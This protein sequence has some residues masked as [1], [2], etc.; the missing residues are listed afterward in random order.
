VIT[1][2]QAV[3]EA[4]GV[5]KLVSTLRGYAAASGKAMDDILAQEARQ[6]SWELYR[7]FRKLSP[8]PADILGAA[9]GRSWRMGRVGNALTSSHFGI[10]AAADRRANALLEGQPSDYFRVTTDG[11]GMLKVRR[12][13]FSGRR[14]FKTRTRLSPVL[15]GGRYGNKFAAGSLRA[16]QV[17]RFE[18]GQAM[19]TNRDIKRLNLGALSAAVEIAF[20]QRAAKGSTLAVQWLPKVYRTRKSSMVKNG[21]LIV[22]SPATGYELGRVSFFSSDGRLNRIRID[23][24][25]P[26]TSKVM[27]R[28]GVFAQVLAERVRDRE[29]YIR[30]KMTG[31]KQAAF[32]GLK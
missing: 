22:N 4:K 12:V 19:R 3:I 23:A 11:G 10:S 8:K 29:K 20:R 18:I 17:S 16:S 24:N 26:G 13:R 31:A 2:G 28:S 6:M 25:A 15:R 30:D 1:A 21:P 14:T 7:Q 5:E 32:R 27:V 9:I